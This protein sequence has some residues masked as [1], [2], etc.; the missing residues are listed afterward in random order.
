MTSHINFLSASAD[1]ELNMVG[2]VVGFTADAVKLE[3]SGSHS[4]WGD[5]N[6][7]EELQDA[8]GIISALLAVM[9]CR[10]CNAIMASKSVTHRRKGAIILCMVLCSIG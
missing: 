5:S 8:S 9:K 6:D 3:L 10:T 1:V 4:Y 7:A 2:L